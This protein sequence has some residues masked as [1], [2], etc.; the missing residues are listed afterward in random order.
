MIKEMDFSE[1]K[2]YLALMEEKAA[3]NLYFISDSVTYRFGDD[4]A[5]YSTEGLIMMHLKNAVF[6]FFRYG[7]YDRKEVAAFIREKKALSVSGPKDALEGLEEHLGEEW[8]YSSMPL[9]EVTRDTFQKQVARSD[10]LSFLLTYEDF[11]A[12]A[13]LYSK[14]EDFGVGL[15]K[16][17]DREEW[18][19]EK[20][21]QMEYP[22][23]ACGYRKNGKLLGTAFLSA[24][25]K[26]SAMVTGVFVEKEERG[27]G[28][29]TQLAQEITDIGLN[30][31]L[32]SRLCLFPSSEKAMK[33]YSRLG[34]R[35]V[36]EYAYLRLSTG[37]K[38]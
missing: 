26:K 8:K 1:L 27:C 29:G 37:K 22:F 24:A 11:L 31:H 4:Y 5:L 20:E 28:I 9:M 12:S 15:E 7:E 2:P 13:E 14:D 17:Q 36:G 23:A 10:N 35:K 18:A 21:K 19:E 32:I 16:E 6:L 34:Y 3:E 30:D 25:T 38:D 33:L